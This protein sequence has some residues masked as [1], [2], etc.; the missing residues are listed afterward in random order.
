VGLGAGGL[1]LA[2]PSGP[3]SSGRGFSVTYTG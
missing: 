2:E 3:D 1:L